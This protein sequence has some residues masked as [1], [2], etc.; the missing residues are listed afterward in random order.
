ML[1]YAFSK[2]QQI[3]THL[4]GSSVLAKLN[5]SIQKFIKLLKILFGVS[6]RA[7]SPE[8]IEKNIKFKKPVSQVELEIHLQKRLFYTTN[9]I[10]LS[11]Q[12]SAAQLFNSLVPRSLNN[13]LRT[14]WC[15]SFGK[16]SWQCKKV[17]LFKQVN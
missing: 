6:E 11:R 3:S 17:L 10:Y 4:V 12:T 1:L 8:P 5:F 9:L 7:T 15:G 2:V 14:H 13:I 16:L